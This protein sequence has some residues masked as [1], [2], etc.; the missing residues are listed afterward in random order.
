MIANGCAQQP[1]PLSKSAEVCIGGV[2]TRLIATA[3]ANRI[4]VVVSQR[5]NLGTLISATRESATGLASG[6][7]CYSTRVLLGRR[8]DEALEVYARTLVELINKSR[9]ADIEFH[10]KRETRDHTRYSRS[11]PYSAVFIVLAPLAFTRPADLL[12]ALNLLDSS[13]ATF[14]EVMRALDAIKVW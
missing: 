12:L 2:S 14:H 6:P 8:D 4:F 3:Y 13:R 1:G 5:E 9:P 11:Q 10:N 7:G